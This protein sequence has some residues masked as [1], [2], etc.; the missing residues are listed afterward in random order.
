ME[1]LLESPSPYIRKKAAFAAVRVVR[2]C[3]DLS[4]NYLEKAVHLFHNEKNH[5]VL[6]AGATLLLEILH[7]N[8]DMA[9]RLYV[10]VPFCV[11]LLRRLS[12]TDYVP[13]YDV[14]GVN[15][16][17]LQV[18]LLR[19]LRL[20]GPAYLERGDAKISGVLKD[21]L[22]QVATNTESTRNV[23]N[24]VLYECV[25][26]IV[27]LGNDASLLVLA[28]NILGRFLKHKDNNIRYVA[29][30]AMQSVMG[31]AP[32]GAAAVQRHRQTIIDCLK[33][34]DISIRRRALDLVYALVDAANVRQLT[35][36]L[37]A[38]LVVA[39]KEFR[40]SI[41]AKLCWLIERYAP[42]KRWQFDTTIRVI[43]LATA[44]AVVPDDVPAGVCATVSQT[45]ELQAY[46]VQRLYAALVKDVAHPDLARIGLWCMGEYGDLLIGAPAKPPISATAED[47]EEEEGNGD[48]SMASPGQVVDLVESVMAYPY[49]RNGAAIREYA[50][51][52]LAKLHCRFAAV[53][54]PEALQACERIKKV[55]AKN[56]RD[57]NVEIQQRAVEF[58]NIDNLNNSAIKNDVYDKMPPIENE[59]LVEGEAAIATSSDVAA[60]TA[61]TAAATVSSSTS[62]TSAAASAQPTNI[63]D[64][65]MGGSGS[66]S[67]GTASA[68]AASGSA[69]DLLADIFGGSG[70][71]NSTPSTDMLGG[72]T[73]VMPQ[74]Q[75]QATS[76]I[77]MLGSTPI[78]QQQ[79]QP[80]P[81]PQAIVSTPAP[82]PAPVVTTTAAAPV[83][84]AE[85]E[86]RTVSVYE[87]NGVSVVMSAKNPNRNISLTH[88]T[89]TFVS[90]NQGCDVSDLLMRVAV[91]KWL[92]LELEPADGSTLKGGDPASKVTQVLKLINN[93]DGAKPTLIRVKITYKV[94]S[95]SVDEMVEVPL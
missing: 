65:I 93:S 86:A 6:L 55:L 87:K 28:T 92:K 24:A 34:P 20:L 64:Q 44:P 88:V 15:D 7:A 59:A 2:K 39:D 3:P 90:K 12:S 69:V 31:V 10:L 89:T 84:P 81:Q 41:V 53:G 70:A 46:A 18:K 58:I 77:D 8:P 66:S 9:R 11:K 63:L 19:L 47:E 25:G 72:M 21:T 78:Q 95:E 76:L 14:C 60:V 75:P 27:A 54:T 32:G 37:L 4:D 68:P 13:E 30:N 26:A 51:L 94:G 56:A 83:H 52:A 40:E 38:Y 67:N 36:E 62:S 61:V 33:D 91:P 48:H 17:F 71:I 79:Q 73:P 43:A 5:G 22:A 35:R 80:Q 85:P 74:Q 16:P 57:V 23:G 42:S 29:L 82:A 45:P 1:K 50:V 49:A